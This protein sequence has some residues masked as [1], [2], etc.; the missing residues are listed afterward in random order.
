MATTVTTLL[1]THDRVQQ[2]CFQY[3][4][5]TYPQTRRTFWHTSNELAPYPKEK[6]SDFKKRIFYRKAIGVLPG[7]TDLV[8]YWKGCLY[9]FDVKVGND[10]ISESQHLFVDAIEA[11]GGKFY[12]INN[13]EQFKNVVDKLV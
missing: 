13:L 9:V 10:V 1:Q 7:V 11:Q 5:N 12:E 2:N 3:L 6:E 8:W 4:W